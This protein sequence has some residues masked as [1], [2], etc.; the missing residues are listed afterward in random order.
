[1]ARL[2]QVIGVDDANISSIGSVARSSVK[3]VLGVSALSAEQLLASALFRFDFDGES[4]WKYEKNSVFTEGVN[5]PSVGGPDVARVTGSEYP[6]GWA[7]R[8]A[9]G[10]AIPGFEMYCDSFAHD[11]LVHD[12]SLPSNGVSV[13]V[14]YKC[15]VAYVTSQALTLVLEGGPAGYLRLLPNASNTQIQARIQAASSALQSDRIGNKLCDGA[16]HVAILNYYMNGNQQVV[17]LYI[18]GMLWIT[19]GM[20]TIGGQ[21][22]TSTKIAIGA[23][24]PGWYREAFVMP[25]KMEV[26]EIQT[27]SSYLLGLIPA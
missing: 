27:L 11:A 6:S 17:E 22:F 7:M 13:G 10:T 16:W 4:T 19:S 12:F 15:E 3:S 23:F 14:F 1:M 24:T 8:V 26:G 9:P 18:D 21:M 2:K 25:G 5:V 20:T